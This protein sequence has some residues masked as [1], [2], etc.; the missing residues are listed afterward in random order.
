[1]VSAPPALTCAALNAMDREAFRAALGGIF[2]DSPWVAERAWDARPFANLAEVHAAMCAVV[3]RAPEAERLALL[4]AHPDLAGRAARARTM[5]A[6]SIGEQAAAG[7]DRL[8]AAEFERFARLN[9]TY[10][11]RFGFPFILAVRGRDAAA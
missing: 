8:D 1:M 4:R 11:E 10:R 6:A 9:A 3:R 5:S 7:L 2:E